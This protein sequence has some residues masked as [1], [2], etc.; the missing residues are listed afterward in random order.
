[1]RNNQPVTA[2][3]R[4]FD[5]SVKLISVTDLDGTILDCNDDFISIS[6]YS[7]EEL[8]GKP[9]NIV[10]HPDMPEAA[11]RV[12]W[13]Y[14]KAGKAWM[15]MVKN[16]CKNGDYYWVDAYVTPITENGRVIGYESVRSCPEQ[17][18]IARAER[19]YESLKKGRSLGI[20]WRIASENLFLIVSLLIS[21]SIFLLGQQETSEAVLMLTVIFYA[22]WVTYNKKI[23]IRSLNSLLEGTFTDQLAAQTYTNDKTEIGIVKVAI[24]SQKAHLKT[25]ISRIENAAKKVTQESLNGAELTELSLHQ[26]EQQQSETIQ[27]ATAMNEMTM[28]I[29][30]VSR[31]VAATAEYAETANDLVRR[32]N[33]VA[34]ITRQSIDN[35]RATVSNISS[36]VGHVSEHTAKISAAAKIIEQ[37]ADQ[38]NLL[39]LNAAIEAA[40]AGDQGR[41]FA[42]V[43]EEVRNLAKRTQES[44]HEIYD[45]VQQLT[46]SSSEAVKVAD[47]GN[48][49]A[50]E[51]AKNVVQTAEMLQGIAEAVGEIASMSTQMSVAVEQQAHVAEDINRQVVTISDHASTSS[52]SAR[53]TSSTIKSL[54]LISD[55]L[56]E[57]VSRFNR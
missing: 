16:R 15:G 57:L 30:E 47:L 41:G 49:S 45:I 14:L 6:G 43:A 36:S 1:M 40:R 29:Q 51:G 12:M 23:T 32:G 42:V 17:V 31:H 44:T 50:E 53:K 54:K 33:Q 39:A 13:Q 26:I 52:E 19:L 56:H 35:L 7:R 4:K 10:R 5:R 28:T 2:N 3:E 38:T 48:Q 11:F 20:G 27:V 8:I 55:S 9:H 34:A 21:G 18:D 37:I 22:L 24:R 25:I 46:A